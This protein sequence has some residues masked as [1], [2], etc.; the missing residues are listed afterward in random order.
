[1]RHVACAGCGL[2][3]ECGVTSP[4]VATTKSST[5][6]ESAKQEP[7]DEVAQAN[8]A[9]LPVAGRVFGSAR[10]DRALGEKSR[11]LTLAELASGLHVSVK[12]RLA[13]L[14]VRLQQLLVTLPADAQ[15]VLLTLPVEQ[16][17]D[18]AELLHLMGSLP[19]GPDAPG[20]PEGSTTMTTTGGQGL[21]SAVPTLSATALPPDIVDFLFGRAM[22]PAW[23]GVIR[24]SMPTA[25][26]VTGPLLITGAPAGLGPLSRPRLLDESPEAQRLRQNYSPEGRE[27]RRQAYG[28]Y[29]A[30]HY[31]RPHPSG[32][33]VDPSEDVQQFGERHVEL[34][35]DR[36]WSESS[37][38]GYG[39]RARSATDAAHQAQ[40]TEAKKQLQAE[41]DT[42]Q[43]EKDNLAASATPW[44]DE[45]KGRGKGRHNHPKKAQTGVVAQIGAPT[46]PVSTPAESKLAALESAP[47][48]LDTVEEAARQEWLGDLQ[49]LRAAGLSRMTID[50]W[51][52]V[53]GEDQLHQV[54]AMNSAEMFSW[55]AN[56]LTPTQLVALLEA[57][58]NN[59][60]PVGMT[61][62]L[63]AALPSLLG[64]GVSAKL[65][66][67]ALRGW[68]K[69]FSVLVYRL[70][71][72]L[73]APQLVA[74]LAA[75]RKDVQPVGLTDQVVAAV[76]K[77]FEAGADGKFVMSAVHGLGDQL[78]VLLGGPPSACITVLSMANLTRVKVMVAGGRSDDLLS[79]AQQVPLPDLEFLLSCVG[80]AVG[81][82]QLCGPGTGPLV[83]LLSA[84][85]PRE[86]LQLWCSDVGL[87]STAELLAHEQFP[88]CLSILP[89]L[90]KD[91][92]G[93]GQLMRTLKAGAPMK[94]VCLGVL[95]APS[96]LHS[97]A[98]ALDHFCYM[99]THTVAQYHQIAAA[100]VANAASSAPID[101]GIRQTA[102]PNPK[103]YRKWK[104]TAVITDEALH[105]LLDEGL[106]RIT[107]ISTFKTTT[108]SEEGGDTEEYEVSTQEE[109]A[110]DMPSGFAGPGKRSIRWV[111]RFVV[112][113][114]RRKGD[115]KESAPIASHIKHEKHRKLKEAKRIP[116][117]SEMAKRCREKNSS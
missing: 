94:V 81:L 1:M 3:E 88:V 53:L 2:G 54:V 17:L 10:E 89:M 102:G 40:L 64:A 36:K 114:H 99:P 48:D 28:S 12:R 35:A 27:K 97:S 18:I 108:E 6:K 82:K 66:I 75:A 38:K 11:K 96:L 57:T 117:G 93:P 58:N 95:D 106:A 23:L 43:A 7:T 63:A 72:H 37:A 15:R 60:L 105:M 65:V 68:G 61:K 76:P 33:P 71:D 86:T 85:V 100:P 79:L 87:S 44:L 78:P 19:A 56:N 92:V 83:S 110:A 104:N 14:P 103:P 32:K 90:A 59:Q 69:Q 46:L 30:T 55:L 111:T 16:Q 116:I 20:H 50:N 39:E 21:L 84:D 115:N 101:E 5:T 49:K 4:L 70:I 47:P 29:L 80:S 51:I 62:D 67:D 24:L 91:K 112:H 42:L 25:P 113:L 31:E 26:A 73:T 45:K 109:Y 41:K 52:A 9:Y 22:A 8:S 77:L 98:Q 13:E 107:Y 34:L 74:L